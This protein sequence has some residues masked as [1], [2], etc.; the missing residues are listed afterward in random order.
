MI[1]LKNSSRIRTQVYR[2][3]VCPYI[4]RCSSYPLKC[5]NCSHNQNAK[6]DYYTPLDHYTDDPF[7]YPYPTIWYSISTHA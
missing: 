1:D 7:K 4:G 3:V 2:N 5:Y 6:K